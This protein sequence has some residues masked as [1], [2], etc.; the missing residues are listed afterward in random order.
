M[1]VDIIMP[2]MN[3]LEFYRL[4]N[5][6]DKECKSCFFS[7]SETSEEEIKNLFPDLKNRKTVLIQKPIKLKDLSIKI[8]EILDQ[9]IDLLLFLNIANIEWSYN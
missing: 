3:G 1:L 8:M 7:A 2:K 4:L 5:E 6:M 9:L